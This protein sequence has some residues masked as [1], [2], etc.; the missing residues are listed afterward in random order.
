MVLEDAMLQMEQ[1]WLNFG[2]GDQRKIKLMNFKL[3][4]IWTIKGKYKKI[5][6]DLVL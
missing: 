2:H 1:Q 6:E 5:T 4:L 3:Q